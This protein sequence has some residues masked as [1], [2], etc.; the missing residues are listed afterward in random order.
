MNLG[1]YVA[2]Y[3]CCDSSPRA[4]RDWLLAEFWCI[5]VKALIEIIQLQDEIIALRAA[6]A[7]EED[8]V[9]GHNSLLAE[10]SK[11]MCALIWHHI[12]VGVALGL[13]F[14]GL[15]Q[16]F[17]A[18]LHAFRTE[19]DSWELVQFLARCIVS[20]TTDFG[21]ESGLYKVPALDVTICFTF[22]GRA[23]VL[24]MTTTTSIFGRVVFA[25][26]PMG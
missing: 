18:L 8:I 14:Q 21:T 6:R 16:K 1:E 23:V 11:K 12:L 24:W 7:E 4:G 25:W 10:K 22:G 13:G 2:L 15:H 26:C 20:I 9:D 19:A 17:I 5:S 3:F